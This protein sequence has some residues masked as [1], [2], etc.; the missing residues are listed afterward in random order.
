MTY[1]CYNT[2]QDTSDV[3]IVINVIKHIHDPKRIK[4]C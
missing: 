3:H 1:Y 4:P 2:Y